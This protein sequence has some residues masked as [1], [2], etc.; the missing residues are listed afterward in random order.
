MCNYL[1]LNAREQDGESALIIAAKKG[2]HKRI[3]IL[4]S[5][6]A[7]VNAVD[8]VVELVFLA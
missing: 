4:A 8:K 6:G 2:H 7:D 3:S 1:V 5:L